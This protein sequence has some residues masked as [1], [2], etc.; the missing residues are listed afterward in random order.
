MNKIK[1]EKD[2]KIKLTIKE[3][4]IS[5]TI[6]EAEDLIREIEKVLPEED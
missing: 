3:T 5:L 1:I 2:F 4:V 6:E